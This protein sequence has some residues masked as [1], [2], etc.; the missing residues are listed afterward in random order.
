MTAARFHAALAGAAWALAAPALSAQTTAPAPPAAPEPIEVTV[1]GTSVAR[2]AGSAHVIREE[3]LAR[4]EHDDP[5]AVLMSVPGVYV[6]GEDGFGLRPNIGLRGA[7]SDRSKKLALME[8]GVPFAPAPYSAPAAYYFPLITRMS[9]VRVIKGPSAIRYG[10]Q[11]IG[12]ALDLRTRSIPSSARGAV[13]AAGGD[14]G[15]RKL[16]AWFGS[17]DERSGFLVEGVHLG[18]NGFKELD[19]GGDTGFMRNEWMLKAEHDPDPEAS[20]RHKLTL[21]LGYSDEISDETYLGLTDADFRRNPDRRYRASRFDRMQWHRTQIALGHTVQ[22]SPNVELSTTVYRN[23]LSRAWR[24]LNRFRGSTISS[25]LANPETARNEIFYGVLTGEL[26]AAGGEDTL[27]IGPN[28]RDFVAQGVEL[29]AKLRSRSGP[30][31]HRIEYGVR[32]HHDSVRRLH[33]ESGF[34]MQG[35]ELVAEAPPA[36]LQSDVTADETARAYALALH[37]SDAIR[38]NRLTVTPGL[39]VEVVRGES[40]DRLN[41]ER[42]AGVQ[43]VFLPGLGVF[44]AL[45]EEFGLLA[46]VHQGFSPAPPGQR[47]EPE[48][49]TNYEAGGRYVRDAARAE[50]IGFFSDYQNLSDVCTFSG[51]CSD[52]DV[53]RQF[54][55]G[56]ARIFGLEAFAEYKLEPGNG[57][58]VPASAAYTLTRTEF[59]SSFDST[60]PQWGNVEE[61]DEMPYVPEHQASL[62]AGIGQERWLV[63]AGFTY[64]SRMREIAGSGEPPSAERTDEQFVVDGSAHYQITKAVRIYCNARNLL[65]RRSIVARRPYGARPNA[66]RSVQ[67]GVKIE[68]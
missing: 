30:L 42:G 55:A 21:K 39:R 18:S 9:S 23:E 27:L 53:D 19:G 4:S 66:P 28:Q 47:V 56:R 67:L 54:D 62:S 38:W 49:S 45:T 59:L 20:A 6:R 60:D 65:D 10:P 37:A 43:Q 5:H 44:Y 63:N 52:A 24:K 17:S 29:L 58:I 46:G 34:L 12:G 1:V 57:W 15:Y 7:N 64:V 51:G 36:E 33:T 22:F 3:K 61:G 68:L 48:L 14:R 40:E 50:L 2:T 35:G 31:D 13:D 25:V 11:T 26:D 8:D 32:L 41:A 16:H